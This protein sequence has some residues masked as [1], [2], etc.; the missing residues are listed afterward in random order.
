MKVPLYPPPTSACCLIASSTPHP[1]ASGNQD[2]PPKFGSQIH[3]ANTQRQYT[4]KGFRVTKWSQLTHSLCNPV[5]RH[6]TLLFGP[7]RPKAAMVEFI[8]VQCFQC[9]AYQASQFHRNVWC[10]QKQAC[11]TLDRS[12]L[13]PSLCACACVVQ[14]SSQC[15]HIANSRMRT[16]AR[17]RMRL[18]AQVHTLQPP[19][20]A[21]TH[22]P[23]PP[24][25]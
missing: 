24:P 23:L 19:A 13:A 25:E 6:R 5:C 18:R 8:C 20:Y 3:N 4:K 17:R 7:A 10:R 14:A 16:H 1:S 2:H 15:T 12:S 22:E 11:N 21:C 9:Q